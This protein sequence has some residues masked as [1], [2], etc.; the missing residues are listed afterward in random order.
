MMLIPSCKLNGI[1]NTHAIRILI[2]KSG[3][4]KVGEISDS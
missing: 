4:K 2:I 3:I 1:D